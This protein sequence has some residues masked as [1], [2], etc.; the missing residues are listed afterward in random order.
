MGILIATLAIGGMVPNIFIMAYE[1]GMSKLMALP[2]V[3]VW[4][5]LC[6]LVLWLLYKSYAGSLELG[7]PYTFFLIILLIINTVSLMFDFP[8][9]WKWYSGDRAIA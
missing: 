7:S 5:P 4:T 9:I 3:V 6:I 8:D 1:R 2:H